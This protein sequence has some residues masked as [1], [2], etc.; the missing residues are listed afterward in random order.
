MR[1]CVVNVNQRLC[2]TTFILFPKP[3]KD[4][5]KANQDA[6]ARMKRVFEAARHPRQ[7]LVGVLHEKYRIALLCE[8]CK[9]PSDDQDLWY[10]VSK[11]KEIV[12]KIL[13]LAQAG[14]TLM[15]VANRAAAVARVFGLPV[16]VL[17]DETFAEGRQFLEAL[18]RDSLEDFA[19]LQQRVQENYEDISGGDARP[20]SAV[21]TTGQLGYCVREF[22]RFLEEVD[23]QKRWA[24]LSAR[25]TP[26]GD[27][28]FACP[29]CCSK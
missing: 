21:V 19:Q 11:P 24:N 1:K 4:N 5:P 3:G 14:M 25:A 10:K 20:Q 9:L 23:P 29:S 6:L 12:G 15:Y 16:P 13:P 26:D 22:A 27:M 18:G 2:P 7:A 17:Q 8:V 28:C